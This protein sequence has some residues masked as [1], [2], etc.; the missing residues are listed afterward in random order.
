MGI[1]SSGRRGGPEVYGP[2]HSPGSR[3]SRCLQ[4][5]R[6]EKPVLGKNNDQV[7]QLLG[8]PLRTQAISGAGEFWYYGRLTYDPITGETDTAVQIV[9]QE[10]SVKDVNCYP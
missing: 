1:G 4:A 2:A 3:N 9:F 7:L 10:N 8:R 5:G 6:F